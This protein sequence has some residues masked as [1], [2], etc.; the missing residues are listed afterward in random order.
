MNTWKRRIAAGLFALG[1]LTLLVTVSPDARAQA[2]AVHP[3]AV[4]TSIR[5]TK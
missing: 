2:Q 5:I 3:A 1:V 4:V